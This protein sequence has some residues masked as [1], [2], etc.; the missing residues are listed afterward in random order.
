MRS[1]GWGAGRQLA[2]A[3]HPGVPSPGASLT[4][5]EGVSLFAFG[6]SDTLS[7]KVLEQSWVRQGA[8]LGHSRAGDPRQVAF[9]DCHRALAPCVPADSP[10]GPWLPGGWAVG[11]RRSLPL[12]W[13]DWVTAGWGSEE[14]RLVAERPCS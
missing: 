10:A 2:R 13:R 9:G 12:A 5:E 1:W 3:P 4:Q 7:E 14:R 8:F 6:E 11:T